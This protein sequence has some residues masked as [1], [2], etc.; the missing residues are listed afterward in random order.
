MPNADYSDEEKM[1]D[2][3][4]GQVLEIHATDK[5]PKLIWLHGLSQADMN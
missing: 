5:G 3:A 2:L 1:N 4:E